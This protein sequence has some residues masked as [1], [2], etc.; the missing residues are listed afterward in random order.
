MY[1]YSYG[2]ELGQQ[3]TASFVQYWADEFEDGPSDSY[4]IVPGSIEE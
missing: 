3:M 2:Y 1:M 4:W